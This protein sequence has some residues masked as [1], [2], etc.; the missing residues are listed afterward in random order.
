MLELSQITFLLSIVSKLSQITSL[1]A[2]ATPLAT[3]LLDCSSLSILAAHNAYLAANDHLSLAT[4]ADI[5]CYHFLSWSDLRSLPHSGKLIIVLL[6]TNDSTID[7]FD[8]MNL[9]R[10]SQSSVISI[11]SL[12]P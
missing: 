1:L 8:S 10:D 12:A 9:T 11:R 5:L 3:D 6:L 7:N 2:S 4:L